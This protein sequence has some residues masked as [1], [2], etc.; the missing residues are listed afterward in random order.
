MA[1]VLVENP[2]TGEHFPRKFGGN[3]RLPEI[4]N[5]GDDDLPRVSSFSPSDYDSDS[6]EEEI[7]ALPSV[8][9]GSHY[10]SSA[11]SAKRADAMS[12]QRMSKLEH[13]T[14]ADG[15]HF[16][17]HGGTRMCYDGSPQFCEATP[18]AA[19][20]ASRPHSANFDA[21]RPPQN[22]V[23]IPVQLGESLYASTSA[24]PSRIK[25][26]NAHSTRPNPYVKQT[27]SNESAKTQEKYVKYRLRNK[28]RFY[29]D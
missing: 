24:S 13:H 17:C 14:C 2:A 23:Q 16:H 8:E 26:E 28:E 11:N 1:K 4:F 27:K 18:T 19:E 21:L 20:S 10:T 12:A 6:E 5:S 25:Q 9:D 22:Y 29:P 15:T 3:S 7:A